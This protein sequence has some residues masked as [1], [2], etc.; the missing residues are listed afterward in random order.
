MHRIPRN[1]DQV[2]GLYSPGFLSNSEP[3]LTFQ[4]QHH[5]VMIRLDMDHIA[6]ALKNVHVAGDVL[7]I[8]EK[9]SF[10]WIRSRCSIGREAMKGVRKSMEVLRGS[11][12]G[13]TWS[14]RSADLRFLLPPPP[15]DSQLLHPVPHPSE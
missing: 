7:S 4:N 3:A 9:R 10:D 6:T 11:G 1:E 12:A 2:P 5:F 15:L 13:S 14:M 8:K